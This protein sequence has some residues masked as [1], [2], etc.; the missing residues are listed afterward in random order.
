MSFVAIGTTVAVGNLAVGVKGS[1]DQKKSSKAAAKDAEDRY[2]AADAVIKRAQARELT[3]PE[4]DALDKTGQFIPDLFT[5]FDQLGRTDAGG[6]PLPDVLSEIS[7]SFAQ[8]VT[9]ARRVLPAAAELSSERQR[10]ATKI[11]DQFLEENGLAAGQRSASDA[12]NAFLNFDLPESARREINRRSSEIAFRTGTQNSGPSADF[13]NRLDFDTRTRNFFAALP[14]ANAQIMQR[15]QFVQPGL[16]TTYMPAGGMTLAGA[17]GN[18]QL[19][20]QS[21]LMNYQNQLDQNIQRFQNQ[22]TERVSNFERQDAF[23]QLRANIITGQGNASQ[24]RANA[25]SAASAST[26]GGAFSSA[27]QMLGTLAGNY[28]NAQRPPTSNNPRV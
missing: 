20:S 17:Q 4:F 26:L 12:L 15:A 13:A 10:E 19:R 22:L 9:N 24:Q 7:R 23:D 1:I 27:G 3:L 28:Y 18:F 6:N 8:D 14:Q 25:L 21:A 5:V 2:R 16:D 11:Y